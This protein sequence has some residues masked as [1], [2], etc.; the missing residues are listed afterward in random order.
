MTFPLASPNA[1]ILPTC[2]GCRS[3]HPTRPS[4]HNNQ[5]QPWTGT[6]EVQGRFFYQR[7][8]IVSRIP[9]LH[10][11]FL[12]IRPFKFNGA[13]LSPLTRLYYAQ[14]F[15]LRQLANRYRVWRRRS[16]VTYR[17]AYSIVTN[18]IKRA[19]AIFLD[20][21]LLGVNFDSFRSDRVRS[22]LA[23]NFSFSHLLNLDNS[24]GCLASGNCLH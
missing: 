24:R 22:R 17:S 13:D 2:R 21:N 7:A 23:V 1:H 4:S 14:S 11:M 19:F 9:S 8:P 18:F 15:P 10:T 20:N 5:S 12:R 6:M 16:F 3:L